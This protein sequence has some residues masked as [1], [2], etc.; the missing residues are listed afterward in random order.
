MRI[1]E[2]KLMINSIP[3]DR[4]GEDIAMY[5]P[6]YQR[7]FKIEAIDTMKTLLQGAEDRIV[8]ITSDTP[9]E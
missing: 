8:L 5:H 4:L 3:E 9:Y 6:F 7:L 2:L 1:A